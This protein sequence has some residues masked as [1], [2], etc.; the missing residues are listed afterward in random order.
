MDP[1][2]YIND[3]IV[4][5]LVSQNCAV[6]WKNIKWILS[7]AQLKMRQLINAGV[8]TVLPTKDETSETIVRNLHSQ[9][10]YIYNCKKI[11]LFVKSLSKP[12]RLSSRQK[13]NFYWK[14]HEFQVVFTVSSLVGI[15]IF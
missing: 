2:E 8:S 9:F 15:T 11:S 1:G 4:W 12:L 6:F 7:T 10:P 14:S 13:I 5:I 3:N